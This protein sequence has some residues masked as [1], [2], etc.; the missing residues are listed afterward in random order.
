MKF[1][2]CSIELIYLNKALR[3]D[4]LHQYFHGIFM[5]SRWPTDFGLPV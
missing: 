3:S 2:I 1:A 4:N 5:S